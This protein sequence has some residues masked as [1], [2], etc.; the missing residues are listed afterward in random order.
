[1]FMLW[2]LNLNAGPVVSHLWIMGMVGPPAHVFC[3]MWPIS[4]V[5]TLP[6]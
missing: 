3:I 6:V 2:I 4:D 1:L 5:L